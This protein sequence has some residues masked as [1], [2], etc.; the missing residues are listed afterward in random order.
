[1]Y[2]QYP[3]GPYPMA[4]QPQQ[5]QVIILPPMGPAYPPLPPVPV[6]GKGMKNGRPLSAKRIAKI[7]KS[8]NDLL[9][10]AKK[11]GGGDKKD[12]KKMKDHKF[13]WW[14]MTMLLCVFSLPVAVGML[15]MLKAA[16]LML[17]AVLAL[18]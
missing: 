7:A 3:F 5:P 1:M 17:K 6:T 16:S 9:E 2:G 11:T 4:Q 8:W 14:D 15:A 12:D 18:P 13:S 10:E